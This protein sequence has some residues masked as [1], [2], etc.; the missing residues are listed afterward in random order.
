MAQWHI[1]R[2][3]RLLNG[4]VELISYTVA[5]GFAE[6]KLA[7]RINL[8]NAQFYKAESEVGSLLK[9]FKPRWAKREQYSHK[10]KMAEMQLE[11]ERA[12]KSII[13][14]ADVK[15]HGTMHIMKTIEPMLTKKQYDLTFQALMRKPSVMK[16]L[17]E[18]NN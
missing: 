9:P 13:K 18:R 10:P 12:A 14:A 8:P 2:Y 11:A 7:E 17:Y 5:S 3:A 4:E 1:T 16:Y 15:F 6:A